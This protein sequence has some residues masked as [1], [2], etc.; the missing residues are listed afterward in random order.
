MALETVVRT[1]LRFL[2]VFFSKSQKH[3]LTFLSC[4]TRFLEHCS[5][6]EGFVKTVTLLCVHC[7]A[8]RRRLKR[9]QRTASTNSSTVRGGGSSATP[10]VS[11]SRGQTAMPGEE[12]AIP[13]PPP[14]P[15]RLDANGAPAVTRW[16]QPEHGR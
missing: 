4:R 6:W 11:S 1:F 15:D 13:L 9:R 2:N 12:L 10:S 3:D 5:R 16:N 7:R 14:P 8:R